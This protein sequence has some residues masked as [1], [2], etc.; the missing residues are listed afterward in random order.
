VFRVAAA[1]HH[2][3]VSRHHLMKIIREFGFHL[4][5]GQEDVLFNGIDLDS[6]GSIEVRGNSTQCVMYQNGARSGFEM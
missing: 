6:N 3:I 2:G 1:G 4:S 5:V